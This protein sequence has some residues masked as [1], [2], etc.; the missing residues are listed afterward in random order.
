MRLSFNPLCLLLVEVLRRW[1]AGFTLLCSC[2]C[3]TPSVAVNCRAK[4]L[5]C[6]H[7]LRRRGY[8][9]AYHSKATAPKTSG[10]AKQTMRRWSLPASN[11]TLTV[12]AS[13]DTWISLYSILPFEPRDDLFST[14]TEHYGGIFASVLVASSA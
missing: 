9:K 10:P 3:L 13:S 8:T 14:L 4:G 1:H 6:R 12:H 2:V 5:E 11:K 7:R